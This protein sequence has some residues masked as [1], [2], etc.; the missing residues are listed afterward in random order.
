MKGESGGL[1]VGYKLFSIV[2]EE[3]EGIIKCQQWPHATRGA[4]AI[5]VAGSLASAWTGLL[6]A[7]DGYSFISV[8]TP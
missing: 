2:W 7:W 5:F 3:K 6:A 8:S 4:D 1:P